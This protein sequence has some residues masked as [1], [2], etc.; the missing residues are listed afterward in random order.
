MNKIFLLLILPVSVCLISISS[1]I[2]KFRQPVLAM[3]AESK[4]WEETT[5]TGGVNNGPYVIP[6]GSSGGWSFYSS[7]SNMSINGG[8]VRSSNG[9]NA[10]LISSIFDQGEYRAYVVPL[11]VDWNLPE[12]A[13]VHGSNTVDG[14]GGANWIKTSGSTLCPLPYRYIQYKIS[15]PVDQ[16]NLDT[17]VTAVRFVG[18]IQIVSGSVV[19]S[20][21]QS[22]I[23]NAT[24]IINGKSVATDSS[25]HYATPIG[26]IMGGK[27]IVTISAPGYQTLTREYTMTTSA[28]GCSVDIANSSDNKALSENTNVR[29][30][31]NVRSSSTNITLNFTLKKTINAPKT[32]NSNI[33][34]TKNTTPTSKISSSAAKESQNQ[35]SN[36][37]NS[38]LLII[39][40]L[41][42]LTAVVLSGIGYLAYR[43][44]KAK[45]LKTNKEPGV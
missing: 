14:V 30:I 45:N 21:T 10:E 1:I 17:P 18:Q 6:W 36:K 27:V 9:K 11:S 41:V 24:V 38:K 44:I 42:V 31:A 3:S 7:Q 15:L 40:S 33:K 29:L 19:D 43:R 13:S 5:F 25:G 22:P 34:T 28:D 26:F 37:Q 2:P 16:I 39:L 8:G 35:K 32:S 23:A 4:T 12:I 20:D